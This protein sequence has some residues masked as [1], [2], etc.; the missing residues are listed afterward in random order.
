MWVPSK[1]IDWFTAM[2]TASEQHAAVS[3]VALQGMQ[4]ELAAVRAERDALKVQMAV[5]QTNFDWLR[6]RVNVLEV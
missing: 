2:K 5:N 4:E 1:V 6:M 3:V